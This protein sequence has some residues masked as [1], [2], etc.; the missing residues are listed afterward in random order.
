MLDG[1]RMFAVEVEDPEGVIVVAGDEGEEE[2]SS[3]SAIAAWSMVSSSALLQSI[4]L[5]FVV[6]SIC[7]KA[8]K[9]S[10]GVGST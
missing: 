2:A 1:S 7:S 9:G 3:E 5:V 4:S 6:I 8:L 10:E